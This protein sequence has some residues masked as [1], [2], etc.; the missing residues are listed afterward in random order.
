MDHG[1][2]LDTLSSDDANAFHYLQGPRVRHPLEERAQQV[3]SLSGP[4]DIAQRFH[5]SDPQRLQYPKR[6]S[7]LAVPSISFHQRP[8][9]D[10]DSNV[11]GTPEHIMLTGGWNAIN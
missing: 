7:I 3:E 8:R 9:A 5:L 4:E 1:D 6:Q 11:S 10:H 2:V